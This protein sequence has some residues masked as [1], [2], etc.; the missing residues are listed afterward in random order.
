MIRVLML[1]LLLLVGSFEGVRASEKATLPKLI[2]GAN[3]PERVLE[4]IT[5]EAEVPTPSPTEPESPVRSAIA[6]FIGIVYR[7]ITGPIRF[8]FYNW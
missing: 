5:R 1:A 3:Q 4:G 2:R 6:S 7:R 8:A